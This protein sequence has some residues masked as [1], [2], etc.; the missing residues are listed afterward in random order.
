MA[1][2]PLIVGKGTNRRRIAP[3]G[4]IATAAICEIKHC[5]SLPH[6]D[7]TVYRQQ[8]KTV[9]YQQQINNRAAKVMDFDSQKNL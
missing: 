9:F 7:P 1:Q 3:Y 6:R 4:R 5:E 8:L 2:M